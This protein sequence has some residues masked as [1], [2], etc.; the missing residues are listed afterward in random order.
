MFRR[1]NAKTDSS[2]DDTC[3]A[4]YSFIIYRYR[5]RYR[6]YTVKDYK[7]NRKKKINVTK[8]ES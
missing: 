7:I 6:L 5:Y 1:E 2:E 4:S 8:K 3:H